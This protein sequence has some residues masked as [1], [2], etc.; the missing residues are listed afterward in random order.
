[1]PSP[2]SGW[3][4]LAYADAIADLPRLR[5]RRS[6]RLL[7]LALA[8]WT[9]REARFEH[10]CAA[11]PPDDVGLSRRQTPFADSSGAGLRAIDWRRQDASTQCR[12]GSG[13]RQSCAMRQRHP[14]PRVRSWSRPTRPTTTTSLRRPVGLLLRVAAALPVIGVPGTVHDRPDTK[15]EELVA[16]PYRF[17][18]KAEGRASSSRAGSAQHSI[19]S[20]AM[21]DPDFPSPSSTH[22]SRLRQMTTTSAQ[23]IASTGWETMLEGLLAAGFAI[24]GTWPIRTE[25]DGRICGRTSNALASSIVLVCRHARCERRR[26]RSTWLPGRPEG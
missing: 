22:S 3:A 6:S 17:G 15:G 21:H 25:R 10:L 8:T 14:R 4:L 5:R 7:E 23:A 26:H 9:S 18:G 12:R 24:D 1:M 13:V 11:G 16:T 20:R 2:S 19:E